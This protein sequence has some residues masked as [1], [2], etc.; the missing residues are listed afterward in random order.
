MAGEKLKEFIFRT[1]L[2]PA[3]SFCDFYK[4]SPKD[5]KVRMK[6]DRKS[7]QNLEDTR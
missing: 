1:I 3:T 7:L 6:G 5:V 2:N 4:K